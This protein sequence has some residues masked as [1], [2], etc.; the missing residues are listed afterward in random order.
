MAAKGP[1]A[2]HIP[3]IVWFGVTAAIILALGAMIAPSLYATAILGSG[4]LAQLLCS[5][6]FVSHRE[7]EAVI[8]ED[9]SGPGYE[10]VSF[11]QWRVERDRKRATASMLGLGRRTA[12]FRE[13]LGCTLVV[14]TTEDKLRAQSGGIFPAPA[15]SDPEALWPKVSESI[16]S[17]R[18]RG[19]AWYLTRRLRLRSRS[20]IPI[21]RAARAP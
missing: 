3:H 7:P 20:L 14:D 2:H 11:F 5:G 15:A 18:L 4:F 12:I 19:T 8:A 13:G 21:T 16:S 10:L 6:T 17:R 1:F 9:M